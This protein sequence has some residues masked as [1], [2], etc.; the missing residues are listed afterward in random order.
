MS[1]Y[2]LLCTCAYNLILWRV[3]LYLVN[4]R[5]RPLA[6]CDQSFL[7]N[8]IYRYFVIIAHGCCSDISSAWGNRDACDWFFKFV[9]EDNFLL[10][11]CGVPYDNCRFFTHLACSHYVFLHIYVQTC[12]VIIMIC[13]NFLGIF[14][15][16]QYYSTCCCVIDYLSVSTVF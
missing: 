10:R 3:K 1:K 14:Y 4:Y 8:V 12:D 6:V 5:P 7:D 16:V 13:V 9:L 2:Y 11:S 15:L